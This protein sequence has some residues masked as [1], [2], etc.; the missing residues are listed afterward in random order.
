MP[1]IPSFG[2]VHTATDGR[3]M[4]I[5]DPDGWEVDQPELW[6]DGPAGSDGTGGPFG[7]PPPGAEHAAPTLHGTAV[8]AVTRCVKLL[9]DPIAGMPWKVYRGREQLPTPSWI[10]DPQALSFDGRRLTAPGPDARLSAVEFWA[11]TITSMLNLGEGMVYTP[12]VLDDAGEPTGPIIAPI[13]NLNPLYVELADDG[14]YYV[15]DDLEPEGRCLPRPARA[16]RDPQHGAARDRCA[17]SA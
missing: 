1:A 4:L 17:G 9:A 12:R 6:W 2:H 13:Y 11:Q 14:R 3:D 8:P 7:N 10:L 16:D 15:E 5:N